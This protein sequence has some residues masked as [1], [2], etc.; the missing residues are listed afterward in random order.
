MIP[1]KIHFIWFGKKPN[2]C[3]NAIKQ[4][5]LYNKDFEICTYFKTIQDIE[6]I[7]NTTYT[8]LNRNDQLIKKCIDAIINMNTLYNMQI[9]RSKSAVKLNFIQILADIFRLEVLNEYGGIYLDCDT[10]PIKSFDYTLLKYDQFTVSQ[11]MKYTN[12]IMPDQF[13]IGKEKSSEKIELK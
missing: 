2:Y 3:D 7:F 11:H 9:Y 10:F 13:F 8:K 5:K 6:L 12:T 4:F 1:K